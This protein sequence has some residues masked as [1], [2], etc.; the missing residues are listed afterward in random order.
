MKNYR[1]SLAALLVPMAPGILGL[2]L[3]LAAGA[4]HATL[5][6]DAA[7]DFDGIAEVD[8]AGGPDSARQ[9]AVLADGALVLAGRSRQ[10]VGADTIDYV[11]VTRMLGTTGAVDLTFGADGTATFLPGLTAS[12]G[13]GG[14]GRAV[15]IQPADQKIIVAG[16][17]KADL[18][19]ARQVFVARLESNGTLDSS[20]GTDGVVLFTPAGVTNPVTNAVALRSDGSIIVVGTDAETDAN[21]GFIAGL[22]A[23]GDVIPGFADVV[24]PNPLAGGAN[25]SLNTVAI[26]PGDGILAGGGGGDLTLARFTSTGAADPGF[27]SD[28]IATFNF[29]TFD[30]AE[31]SNATFDVINELLVLDDGRILMA[32]RAGLDSTAT[33][34]NRILGRVTAAGALDTTFGSGGYA[35]FSKESASEVPDGMGVRP[36]G[37]IVIVGEGFKPVQISPNGIAQSVLPG[38]FSPLLLDLEVL[39]GGDVVA[40]GQAAVSEGNTAL[41]AVRLIAADLAD[42]PDTVPDPFVFATQT[43]LEA[44]TIATSNAVTIQGIESPAAISINF[45]SLYSIGCTDYTSVAGTISNGDTVCVQTFTADTDLTER[46]AFLTVGG[47]IGQFTAITGEAT[48]DT[49]TFTDRVGVPTLAIVDADPITITGIDAPSKVTISRNGQYQIN[50]TGSFTAAPGVVENGNTICVRHVSAASLS[51]QTD[52]VLTVGGVSDTFT[53]TTTADPTPLPGSSSMDAWSLLLLAPLAAYRS[54]RRTA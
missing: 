16:I 43:G 8:I 51:T 2:G 21:A 26:L 19:A 47:V 32:G 15:V 18:V 40:A 35:P 13:A 22:D 7:F 54:R 3:L 38:T 20:F 9:V 30:T 49:F 23:A 34:T 48:P 5:A 33:T 36:S 12:S 17:W 52:T 29:F 27:D 24:V 50:C 11:S 37:D 10:I 41:A 4:A 14:D 39:P 1:P 25:F 45:G 53:S 42:G 31:G 46:Q 44:E 6:L 28:G